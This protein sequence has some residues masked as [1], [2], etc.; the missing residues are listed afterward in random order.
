MVGELDLMKQLIGETKIMFGQAINLYTND[1]RG[2][3][4]I[5]S[6]CIKCPAPFNGHI[7]LDS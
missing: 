6:L 4:G 2:S 7:T 5:R 3:V 1:L